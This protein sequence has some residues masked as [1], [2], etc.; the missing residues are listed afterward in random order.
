MIFKGVNL[1][2]TMFNLLSAYF[3]I[4]CGDEN[5][6]IYITNVITSPIK[7]FILLFKHVV[8]LFVC[9]V[10]LIHYIFAEKRLVYS[11]CCDGNISEFRCKIVN[12][13]VLL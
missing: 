2:S 9:L 11:S 6:I 5:T 1:K 3:I 12:S 10:R 7:R 8:T 4:Y 13:H